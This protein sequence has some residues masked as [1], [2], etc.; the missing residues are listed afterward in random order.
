ME[1]L[2][3]QRLVTIELGDEFIILST[4]YIKTQ[5]IVYYRDDQLVRIRPVGAPDRLYDFPLIDNKFDP[6]LGVSKYLLVKK[7][8]FAGFV[9]Q[10]DLRKGQSVSTFTADGEP[11]GNYTITAVDPDSDSAIFT[12]ETGAELE[13]EFNG[14]GIPL[15]YPFA[16]IFTSD[17]KPPA[18][19]EEAEAP[20]DALEAQAEN[21][22]ETICLEEMMI[23]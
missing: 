19:E 15:G 22:Q 20:A 21:R 13:V 7:A 17:E 9:E 1:D 11:A 18:A 3:D 5:G 2:P 8:I 16:I 14:D 6:E 10:H 4:K 12:D 23:Y